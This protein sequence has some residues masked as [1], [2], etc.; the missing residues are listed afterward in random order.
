MGVY[1]GMKNSMRNKLLSF[2]CVLA[3]ISALPATAENF[4][5]MNY[6]AAGRDLN[7]NG[8]SIKDHLAAGRNVQC[9]D[10]YLQGKIAAGRDVVL[11]RS[12]I[13]GSVAAGRS[14]MLEQ[15]TA[16]HNITAGR[17]LTLRDSHVSGKIT[18]GGPSATLDHSTVGAVRFTGLGGFQS[19]GTNNIQINANGSRASVVS[20]GSNGMSSINGYLIKSSLSQTTLITPEQTV[21]VNGRKTSGA[22][23]DDYEAYRLKTPGAPFLHAP[24]WTLQQASSSAS[25]RDSI[26]YV[27]EMMNGSTVEG[28]VV[29]E[30]AKGKVLL[31]G[32]SLLRGE[33]INGTVE[34]LP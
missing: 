16:T 11:T 8:A 1:R 26:E 24:G 32:A 7:L 12:D 31:H 2:L 10:C 21:Y 3:F 5:F 23:P 17:S 29:F 18:L 30:G 14:V 6:A 9:T 4:R 15:V 19:I 13:T 20:M 33:V 27:L 28:P 34:K 22:G 25:E